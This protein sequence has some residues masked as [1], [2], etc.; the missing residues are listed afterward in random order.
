[1]ATMNREQIQ[2]LWQQWQQEHPQE[3]VQFVRENSTRIIV[4][5]SQAGREALR[6]KVQEITGATES[7][8]TWL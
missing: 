5:G 3:A 2:R 1:M 4:Q 7:E 8:L 6:R